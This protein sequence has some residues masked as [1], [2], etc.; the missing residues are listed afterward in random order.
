MKKI[1]G[2]TLIEIL[3][4]LVI[5]S[6][7]FGILIPVAIV[8]REKAKASNCLSNLHQWSLAFKAYTQDYDSRYPDLGTW[9][10]QKAF[11]IDKM[12]SCPSFHLEDDGSST[13][14][15]ILAVGYART[16]YV[17]NNDL[18]MA[19]ENEHVDST[20]AE[21]F[22]G[23]QESGIRYPSTTILLCDGN[24]PGWVNAINTLMLSDIRKKLSNA[25]DLQYIWQRHQ[26]GGNFIFVDGHAHWYRIESISQS[27]TNNGTAPNFM[28]Q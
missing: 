18:G 26:G 9:A 3:V 7:L 27:Y 10:E 8:S 22:T 2:F 23:R 19:N 13:Y 4:V 11:P 21:P 12:L 6:L 16:G 28:V 20:T 17:Y 25:P 5:L 24:N 1:F 15:R 14:K